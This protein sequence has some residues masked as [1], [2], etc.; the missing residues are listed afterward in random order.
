MTK[1]G[2]VLSLFLALAQ[3]QPE[4]PHDDAP[5]VM[6]T[7]AMT[8]SLGPGQDAIARS[9]L[10]RTAIWVGD[11]LIYTIRIATTIL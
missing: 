10:D 7:P 3:S 8:V 9:A 11:P 1:V 4:Q 2:F 6:P 5:P